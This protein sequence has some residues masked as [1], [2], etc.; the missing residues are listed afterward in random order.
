MKKP[1]A[2][3]VDKFGDAHARE[4]TGSEPFASYHTAASLAEDV[5]CEEGEKVRYGLAVAPDAGAARLGNVVWLGRF[6]VGGG[7]C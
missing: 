3:I 1:F 2:V 6:I 5:A 7:L 4:I